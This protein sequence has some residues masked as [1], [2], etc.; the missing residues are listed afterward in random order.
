MAKEKVILVTVLP[1]IGIDYLLEGG[2]EQE[3]LDNGYIL[4]DSKAL[5]ALDKSREE[6]ITKILSQSEWPRIRYAPL[7]LKVSYECLLED[8]IGEIEARSSEYCSEKIDRFLLALN[9][10][11]RLWSFR[12]DVKLSWFEKD[13]PLSW[14]NISIRHYSP[15]STFEGRPTVADF[16]DAALLTTRIDEVSSQSADQEEIYPAIRTAFSAI[17][18]GMYAFSTSMRLLQEAIALEALCSADTTEVTHRIATTCAL[19]LGSTLEERRQL[20]DEAKDLYGIRSR[21]IHGSGRAVTKEELKKIE[22]LSRKLLRHILG[23]AVL[24]QYRTRSSQKDFLLRLALG[25]V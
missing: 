10:N 6:H 20:Y 22:Q 4:V 23:N 15:L 8:N 1:L 9:V 14:Q 13:Y 18:L 25:R 7:F 12:P 3:D 5:Q 17:K 24:P 11:E 2:K 19:L 21:V 16:R